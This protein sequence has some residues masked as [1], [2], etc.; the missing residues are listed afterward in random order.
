[1]NELGKNFTNDKKFVSP[2][3]D[4]ISYDESRQL[5]GRTLAGSESK[6]PSV[7]GSWLLH[8]LDPGKRKKESIFVAQLLAGIPIHQNIH[9]RGAIMLG[10]RDGKR[11]NRA[12][13]S[14]AIVSD[15]SSSFTTSRRKFIMSDLRSSLDS[16]L[17]RLTDSTRKRSKEERK[18][19]R[20]MTFCMQNVDRHIQLWHHEY[21]P[22][23]EPHWFISIMEVDPYYKNRGYATRLMQRIHDCADAAEYPICT[24]AF[25]KETKYWL[26]VMGYG[27]TGKGTI[28]NDP[29][30]PSL[31]GYIMVRNPQ[32]I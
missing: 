10:E 25:G 26:K 17:F 28:E 6:H 31:K 1:M 32:P 19:L 9:A 16:F 3:W 30:R 27:V 18:E 13:I 2:H 23:N 14:C 5:Y 21:G 7:L 8:S 29:L 22:N 11:N 15:V 4:E 24:V 12:L 20:K